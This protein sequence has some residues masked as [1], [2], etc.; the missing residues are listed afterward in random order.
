MSVIGH[1]WR[2]W[3]VF[4]LKGKGDNKM[5]VS[6]EVKVIDMILDL[7]K[8]SNPRRVWVSVCNI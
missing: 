2:L 1:D 3:P 4:V 5:P 8:C 6:G 7:L